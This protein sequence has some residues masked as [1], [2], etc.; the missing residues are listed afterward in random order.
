MIHLAYFS[1][2]YVCCYVM[3]INYCYYY[4]TSKAVAT[5]IN[6]KTHYSA[7]EISVQTRRRAVSG[8]PGSGRVQCLSTISA[9][10]H[11]PVEQRPM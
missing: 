8:C 6:K 10:F 11:R 7:D 3:Q 5:R 4:L 9:S 2:V 1:Y